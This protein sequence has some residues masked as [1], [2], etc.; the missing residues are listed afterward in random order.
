MNT[1]I[2]T[3]IDPSDKSALKRFISLERKLMKDYPFFISE[4]DSDVARMLTRKTVM[5]NQLEFG[6]F[7][8]SKAKN[9]ERQNNGM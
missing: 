3:T 9:S 5:S 4:I 6:L 2:V 7:D 8:V 1:A